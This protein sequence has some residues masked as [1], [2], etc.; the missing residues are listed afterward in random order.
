MTALWLVGG[1][2]A[3][4]GAWWWRRPSVRSACSGANAASP[5]TRW[6]V[7][8]P[9]LGD[10]RAVISN[11]FRKTGDRREHLGVDLMYPR[12]DV[13]DLVSV[14]APK[15][16]NGTTMFFM[17]DGVVAFAAAAG[18]V[19]FA[20]LTNMGHSVILEHP[21]GAATYYTHLERLAVRRG[22]EVVAG[23]TLGI[24]GA[25]P[26]DSEH[27]KHLHFELWKTGKRSSAID[28]APLLETWSR[29]T[30][31]MPNIVGMHGPAPR[32]GTMS[33]YR[34][35]GER[36]DA[37]PDWVRALRGKAGVYVIRDATT[38]ECLYVGSSTGRLY[39]TLTRHF[40]TWRRWK[41]YWK[42]QYGEGADPGLTYPRAAIE[43]AVRLT[44][45][46][47]ALDDEMRTIARLRPRDNQIGQP[48]PA[49][50]DVPF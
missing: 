8:I 43:V 47:D 22:D 42:D 18:K 6:V 24:I 50:D 13:R 49:A 38:H 20:D 41:K 17:P 12:R 23:Q 1:G 45:P 5:S 33:A 39:G 48:D 46:S 21:N 9:S 10:R 31:S 37:Y 34:R 30:T 11:E 19:K 32:N 27:L 40:Q 44:S 2:L 28:P 14:F 25:N 7:P 4:V 26:S 35:V 29:V 3:A 16:T 15:T 36:G